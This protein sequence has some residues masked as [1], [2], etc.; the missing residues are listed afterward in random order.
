MK[1][2][3]YF[4]HPAQY[5]FLRASI[6][7]LIAAD[8]DSVKIV[9]RSKDVLETLLQSDRLAYINILP[10]TRG[11][12]KLAIVFSLLQRNLKLIPI[13]SGFKPQLLISSDAS[14]A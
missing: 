14:L 4:A 3:F 1:V 13:I 12:S 11:N 6:K 2:L 10:K 5:L 7:K 8:K 9:I